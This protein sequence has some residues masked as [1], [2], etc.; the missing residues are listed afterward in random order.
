[1]PDNIVAAT[2]IDSSFFDF[3]YFISPL[4]FFVENGCAVALLPDFESYLLILY[5]H[6]VVY[7]ISII[8]LLY[9]ISIYDHRALYAQ[10][11]VFIYLLYNF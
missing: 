4:L 5:L 9:Q 7:Q 3:I 6:S 1:M 11:T 10:F 2:K 8:S